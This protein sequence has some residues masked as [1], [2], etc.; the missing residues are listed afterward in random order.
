MSWKAGIWSLKARSAHCR[1][2]LLF[3]NATINYRLLKPRPKL[4][5][6]SLRRSRRTRPRYAIDCSY[7]SLCVS[8]SSPFCPYI[9]CLVT[10][11]PFRLLLK[12]RRP[13]KM[14]NC[15]RKRPRPSSWKRQL[16]LPSQPLHQPPSPHPLLNQRLLPHQHRRRKVRAQHLERLMAVHLVERY[17]RKR[18]L[19]LRLLTFSRYVPN[20]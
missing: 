2:C 19:T 20:E 9:I 12:R 5:K 15:S 13:Q 6:P 14:I 3:L 18:S 1:L 10:F 17:C 16:Q 7:N 4:R 8:G 11:V